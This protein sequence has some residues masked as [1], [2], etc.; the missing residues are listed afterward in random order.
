MSGNER[1]WRVALLGAGYIANA[2]AVALRCRT[3]V[4]LIVVCDRARRKAEDLSARFLI[5]KVATSVEEILEA[6]VDVVHVLLPPAAHVD[7]ARAVLQAGCHAFVEKPL[8]LNAGRCRELTELAKCAGRKL[9]VNHNFLFLP[10]AQ[11]MHR[12]IREGALGELDQLSVKWLHSLDSV[13]FGPFGDWMLEEPRNLFFELG[14]HLLAFVLDFVGPLDRVKAFAGCP[15]DLPGGGRVYRQWKVHG[16]KDRT[17]VD[18]TLSVRKGPSERRVEA[19]GSA[20]LAICDFGRDLYT[21]SAPLGHGLFDNFLSTAAVSRQLGVMAGTNFVRAL[22]GTMKKSPAANPFLQSVANSINLFY[23]SLDGPLEPHSDGRFGAAV[24]TECERIVQ[25]AAFEFAPMKAES[26]ATQPPIRRPSVVVF[27]GSGFIGR[28]LVRALI[29]RGL[30]VRVTTRGLSEARIALAGLPVELVEGDLADPAFVDLAFEG[31]EVVYDLSKAKGNR[32]EEYYKNDVLLTKFV[33]ERALAKGVKRFIYT[34][35]IASY[36][37]ASRRQ[38]IDADTPLDPRSERRDHYARSK[39]TCE[40]LLMSL[41]RNHGLPVVILRP[42]IVIGEGAPSAHWGVGMFE[43]DTR[44]R[45]WGDG[46]NLL[47]FVLVEDVAEALALA[48]DKPGIEGEAFLVVDEPMLSARDYVA[49][50][51]QASGSKIRAEATPIWRFFA[52]DLVKEAAK[53]LIRHPNRRVPSYRDWACRS[54]RAQFDGSKTRQVLGWKPAGTR[55]ALIE[56]GVLAPLRE[57]MR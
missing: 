22:S 35:T 2:H 5:P 3:D 43:S 20:G 47:P 10:A 29:S 13:Q 1:R 45:F 12:A 9:G 40:Q 32:W 11:T 30:G 50:L 57:S 28:H 36:F 54:N 38:V 51:S 56:R 53:H 52:Y 6:E 18:L 8:G 16:Q 44:V 46:R 17:A 55:E 31:I 33:A 21:S 49:V 7:A 25:A 26:R 34:G 4:E 23:D 19:R 39:A 41:Y 15:I 37:S 24:V 48:L 42:G 27:G 14:P